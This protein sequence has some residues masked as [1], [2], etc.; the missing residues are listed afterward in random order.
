MK[1]KYPTT[2]KTLLDRIAAGDEIS[3]D[4]FYDRYCGI[5][6]SLAKFKGLDDAGADDIC[7]QVMLQFFK[8][9]KTFKFDPDIARFRTFFG[10]IIQ[11]KI[12]DHYRRKKEEPSDE[13]GD[14][15]ADVDQN[16]ELFLNEWR[17][18]ILKE[19]ERELKNRVAPETFQAYEL[20]A[21]QNRPVEKVAAY[22]DCSVNQVY[23][24]KKRC[25][26]MMREILLK[27][28]EQDPELELELS[29][30]GI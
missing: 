4:E 30:Y 29:H 17:K 22:L 5:V 19:A 7:Q 8:Q 27:M 12:A 21:V 15:P 23:Q 16:D 14:E 6:R 10:R 2:S 1:L 13:I 11:A 18:M 25:F 26:A 20:Y 28:N 24:A 9:S 3:W